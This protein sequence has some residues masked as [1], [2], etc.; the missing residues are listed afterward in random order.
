MRFFILQ[1]EP[2]TQP[3][4]QKQTER[5]FETSLNVNTKT[6]TVNSTALG[7]PR[8]SRLKGKPTTFATQIFEKEKK[9]MYKYVLIFLKQFIRRNRFGNF[10]HHQSHPGKKMSSGCGTAI[11]RIPEAVLLGTSQEPSF[12]KQPK[13][14]GNTVDKRL[15]FDSV[16]D[17]TRYHQWVYLTNSIIGF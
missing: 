3:K 6:L 16:A 9:N 17:N 12:Q 8:L 5:M 15:I 14:I 7:P 2:N 11:G 13:L 4:I 1:H 10:Y